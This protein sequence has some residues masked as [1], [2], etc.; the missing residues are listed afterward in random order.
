MPSAVYVSA[1]NVALRDAAQR[2]RLTLD[3]LALWTS[4]YEGMRIVICDGSGYDFTRDIQ[5]ELPNANIECLH[6]YNDAKLVASNGKGY[7]EGEIVDYALKHSTYLK[8]AE[9]FAKCTSK[10]FVSNLDAIMMKWNNNFLCEC[11]FV[12][13]WSL[14]KLKLV[15]V[16]TRFYIA[17]KNFYMRYLKDVHYKVRDSDNYFLEHA[18]KD[19]ILTNKVSKIISPVPINLSGISGSSGIAS[20]GYRREWIGYL[21]QFIR[22]L[23]IGMNPIYRS[24]LL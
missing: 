9:L 2:V 5:N 19:A 24:L 16:D 6:F 21:K 22:R 13:Y 15:F 18:F 14:L 7:G 8:S 20:N 12:K 3:S 10:H 17:N 23:I 11:Y 1:T 4:Q